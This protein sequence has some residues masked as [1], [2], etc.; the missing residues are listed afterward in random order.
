MKLNEAQKR[1]IAHK[2]GA[3]LVLAGPGSGKT[4]VI[5]R[6]AL[7][8]IQEKEAAPS[9]ILVVTFTKAAAREM[10]ERFL[11][12]C[13]GKYTQVTFGTFHGIFYGILR[14][15]YGITGSNILGEDQKLKLLRELIRSQ[16]RQLQDEGE[17]L[18]A[19]SREIGVVK[20]EGIA[21]E[22][23][24]STSCATEEFRRVY[25]AYQ[26]YLR[27]NRLMDFDDILRQCYELFVQR[28]D[29]LKAWQRKFTHVLIDE[30]QDIN[31]L[32]YA[33]I[34][35]LAA[36]QDNLF[37]VGDD[38]QS[39][40]RFRGAKPQI[41][42]RFPKDYPQAAQVSLDINYRCPGAVVAAAARLIGHNKKRFPKE[43]RTENLLGEP[44]EILA[45]EDPYKERDW[46]IHALQLDRKHGAAWEDIALLFRTNLGSRSVVEKL[47]EY[48]IPFQ[49]RDALPNLYEHWI[50]RNILAYL[51][52]AAGGSARGDFLQIMN[53]PNR[54]ISRE[55]LAEPQVCFESL[56]EFYQDKRWMQERLENLE[57]DLSVMG[58]MAPYGAIN[59]LRYSV[60]YQD[61]L[62]EYAEYRHIKPEELFEVL[63]AIQESA[64]G[65]KS[66]G[67]WQEQIRQYT[68][69]LEEQKKQRQMSGQG[70]GITVSTLHSIKGLEY[71]HV[72]ILD[73]NE[74]NMPYRKALMEEDLEEERRM[75]YVGMTRA[76]K[77]LHLLYTRK[78]NDRTLEM[79]RFLKEIQEEEP[80]GKDGRTLQGKRNPGTKASER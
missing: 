6:R 67:E 46:L 42:L 68:Q 75:F 12:L 65:C 33:V 77:R 45:F 72:Y 40:Y 51:R 7:Q 10:K 9:S 59:Y 71:D 36:P 26:N 35:M 18:E 50:A 47:M 1:A 60:G 16:F 31:A 57:A 5:T 8:L 53:R 21:P 32:Q 34:R 74:G 20:N 28:P 70:Q 80:C 24:Y 23:Y 49:M 73:V 4:S 39:I 54:Y 41:M 14:H 48:N 61:Y 79:S 43:L 52:L 30:F 38:D 63:D 3:M 19:I 13:Q 44:V 66:T 15:A 2:S 22:N 25:A 76:K 56:Y 55:A 62:K 37:I 11:H 29:I 78:Q 27:E 17:L 64:K 69:G 58:R